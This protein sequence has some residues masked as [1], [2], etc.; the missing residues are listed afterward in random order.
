MKAKGGLWYYLSNDVP[1]FVLGK[2]AVNPLTFGKK[3]I[4]FIN[5]LEKA[6]NPYFY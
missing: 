1:I 5:V 3:N 4:K 2:M 6:Y